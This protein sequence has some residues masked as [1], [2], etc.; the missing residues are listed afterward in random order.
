VAAQAP[1]DV[2]VL[3]PAEQATGKIETQSAGSTETPEVLRVSG[4][5][6]RADDRTWRVGVRTDG[7]VRSVLV[8]LGDVVR[9]DQVLAR[10][11]ADEVR[12]GRAKYHTAIADLQ[13]LEAAA[14]QARRNLDRMQGL[15]DL[16]AA[17]QMQVE[18][19]RQDVVVADT[20]VKNGRTE[21][22]RAKDLLEDEL[23]VPTESTPGQPDA[24]QV[25]IYAPA[26]GFVL[27]KN[28]TPGRTIAPGQDAFVIGD[29]SQVWMLA[30]VRQDLLDQLHTGQSAAVSIQG[31]EQER[32][33]G[34]ITN[35]GQEVDPTTRVLLVRIVVNNPSHRLR[36]E[37]LAAADVA[38]DRKT[39]V[40]T[41]PSDAVQQINGQDIVFVRT[42]T[43][44]FT[45]RPVRVGP[46]LEGRTSVLEGIKAGEQIVV[47]GSF[48]LKSHLLRSTMEGD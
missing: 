14:A 35:L 17:S 47:H 12:E 4:R 6:A 41:V 9:K 34:R 32:F 22:E 2:V 42:A 29:L 33:A 5:I 39:S 8:N 13:K 10:Y 44:R 21:V 40:L 18:Q 1:K 19:A 37:M 23:H 7:L 3:T 11:H 38:L 36:P 45:M 25:P 24:D 15:L 46:T 26:A 28:V 27:E 20:A 48:T 16:K 30:S 31:L 43:D